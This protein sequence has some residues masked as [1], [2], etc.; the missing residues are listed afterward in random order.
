MQTICFTDHHELSAFTANEIANAIINKPTLT[1]CMASGHTPALTCELLVKKLQEEKVDYSSITFLG[2]DEWAGL[3][4]ENEGSC[5]YFFKQKVFEPL[6]LSPS[7]YFLFDAL[8]DNLKTEC[9]KMDSIIEEKGGIDIMVVGIGM[10]GHIGFNE[11]GT[12]FD[13]LSHVAELDETT[14]SVGQ[15]YF[16]ETTALQKG[17]TIGL[18]HLMHAKKV[19]LMANGMKKAEVI[20]KTIEGAVTESF[21]ASIMQEHKNGF[22]IFDE[23][24]AL[25]LTNE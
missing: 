2:L 9:V 24:A 15:K 13:I 20:K 21:P 5:H 17:I 18:G 12:A 4:P 3:P 11:P 25:L 22:V 8:A 14:V 19:F 7:Q 10:N 23:E 16:K 1:L 6:Q